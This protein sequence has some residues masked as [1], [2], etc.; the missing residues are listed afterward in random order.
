[1]RAEWCGG[2]DAQ[3][4]RAVRE[5]DEKRVRELVAAGAKLCVV[6]VAGYSALHYASYNFHERI[7]KLLLDG[8]YEGKGADIDLQATFG[9]FS[10]LHLATYRT[11]EAVVRLLLERGADVTLRSKYSDTALSYAKNKPA[12][13]ALLEAHSARE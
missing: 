8:K 2:R 6:D 13:R 5:G 11:R 12:I 9:G 10:P 3:L 4:I 1:M 7:A